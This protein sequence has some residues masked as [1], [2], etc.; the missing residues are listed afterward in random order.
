MKPYSQDLCEQIIK[1][2]RNGEGSMRD[3]A[4]RFMVSLNFVWLLWQRYL[5]TGS[6][7]PKPHRGGRPSVMTELRLLELRGLVEAQ[8]D[9]TLEELRDRFRQAT[10]VSV[11]VG[12]ISLALKK[13]GLSRKK[14]TFHATERETDPEIVR[15]REEH[16]EKVPEMD[17]QHLVFVDEFG[18]NL[19]MAREH[20]RVPV[21]ERAEGHRPRDA[22][23]N[24][25]VIGA[26]NIRGIV[27]PLMFPGAVNG[28]MFETYVEKILA[29]ELKPG[30]VVLFDNLSSH[31]SS[32]IESILNKVGA[33]SQRL[34]RYS[35]DPSPIENS[36][37]KIKADLRKFAARSYEA[38]VDA[39]RKALD[40]IRDV[41]R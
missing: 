3:I 16:L 28:K 38:L 37:S 2:Y 36:I 30:D 10:G 19:G 8:N 20:G 13:L 33:T 18:I 15:E 11:S 7:D 17:V 9:A 40:N 41:P 1:A 29:P 4:K 34:P 14:K 5:S 23:G 35:P 6:V 32:P 22:G 21:G 27:A 25:T 26:L 39:V 31:K 12:T 24:A